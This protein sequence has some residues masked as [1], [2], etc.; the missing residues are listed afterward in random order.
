MSESGE[1]SSKTMVRAT[2]NIRENNA[3]SKTSCSSPAAEIPRSSDVQVS[4]TNLPDIQ[5]TVNREL[6][7][8]FPR[9]TQRGI[10][11]NEIRK[12]R[13]KPHRVLPCLPQIVQEILRWTIHPEKVLRGAASVSH[14]FSLPTINEEVLPI[15]QLIEEN[16]LSTAPKEKLTLPNATPT[17]NQA[18]PSNKPGVVSKPLPKF[19]AEFR[20]RMQPSLPT[21]EERRSPLLPEKERSS[22]LSL[23]FT[24]NHLWQD[25]ALKTDNGSGEK[26][27]HSIKKRKYKQPKLK[28]KVRENNAKPAK[29]E[30][31]DD[32]IFMTE[33]TLQN[34]ETSQTEVN[35]SRPSLSPAGNNEWLSNNEV[36]EMP[37]LRATLARRSKTLFQPPTEKRKACLPSMKAVLPNIPSIKKTMIPRPPSTP[38]GQ[39]GAL[40]VD[41]RKCSTLIRPLKSILTTHQQV[42]PRPPST[43]KRYPGKPTQM[44]NR[45]LP[46][47]PPMQNSLVPKPPSTPKEMTSRRPVS[48]QFRLNK[49]KK[50][51][52]IQ[53]QAEGQTLLDQQSLVKFPLSSVHLDH[54]TAGGVQ[55]AMDSNFKPLKKEM[56]QS[57][58]GNMAN[59]EGQKHNLI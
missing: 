52:G 22:D 8:N 37:R 39:R 2:E 50:L 13:Q 47:I 25:K 19:R 11:V 40:P 51:P 26:K 29:K 45:S 21:I 28:Q 58:Q 4:L 33:K 9:Q 42:V 24:E 32:V 15:A 10:P 57:G 20:K 14:L 38:K 53:K 56:K 5:A 31:M 1:T 36:D 49:N 46:S 41:T 30:E 54:P 16:D 7:K 27:L 17:K 3:E 44:I 23:E 18:L 34:I 35:R 59:D 55:S 12:V 43:P 48:R 6:P